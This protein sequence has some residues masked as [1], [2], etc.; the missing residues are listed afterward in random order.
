[1]DKDSSHVFSVS[2]FEEY[3]EKCEEEYTNVYCKG[4]LQ[5]LVGHPWND[6]YIM[7]ELGK[8][9]RPS[10][11]RNSRWPVRACI[12]PYLMRTCSAVV[13][14]WSAVVEEAQ[15]TFLE[16]RRHM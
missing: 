11:N 4:W 7:L 14:L 9:D 6:S 16:L 2:P 15:H 1:M 3:Y 5:T 10:Q 8:K 13:D 12:Q